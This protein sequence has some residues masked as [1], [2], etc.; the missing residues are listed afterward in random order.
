V[1][2]ELIKIHPRQPPGGRSTDASDYPSGKE[3]YALRSVDALLERAQRT[4][5]FVG[6][7]VER[8]LDRPLPW[9]KMRQAYGLLRLCDKYG[10]ARVDELC[11][12]A[13]AFDV[14]DVPRI[15][16]ML[17]AARHTECEATER[18]K[19][20]VLHARFARSPETF[21]TLRD[22]RGSQTEEAP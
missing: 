15:Q 14:L 13:L 16:R 19:L 10:V 3:V 18:G 7:Y 9:T 6:A 20:V 4:A 5:P 11:R 8:L 22:S 21:G 17:K 1:G 2:S 12:R